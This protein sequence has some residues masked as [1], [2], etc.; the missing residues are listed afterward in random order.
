MNVTIQHDKEEQVFYAELGGA[1]A[2]LTYTIPSDDSINMMHTYV[3]EE[4]RGNGI[5]EQ[6]VEAALAYAKQNDY[7]VIPSCS[8]VAR[9][10]HRQH[11]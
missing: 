4:F 6:L 8:F 2:E 5:G 7:R 9:Y 11:R 10:V 3:P 1:V